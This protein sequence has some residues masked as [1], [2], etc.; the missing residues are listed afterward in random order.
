M[1]SYSQNRHSKAPTLWS[2][3]A[4]VAAARLL[5]N[6]TGFMVGKAY[7]AGGIAKDGAKLVLQ[8]RA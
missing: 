7:E 4:N 1:E 6:V 5:Q 8:F 3:V 2:C